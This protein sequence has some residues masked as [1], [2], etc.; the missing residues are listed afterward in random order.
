MILKRIKERSARKVLNKLLK[1]H[2]P[3]VKKADSKESLTIGC[4]VDVEVMPDVT[5]MY[6]LAKAFNL[7]DNQ[8]KII[9]YQDKLDSVSPFAVP[10]FSEAD[11]GWNG[12]IKSGYV[13]EF[14]NQEFDVLINYYT[15][16]KLPLL[17]L[18]AKTKAQ[19]KVGFPVIN[20]ELNNLIINVAP[21][22]FEAF[23]TELKKYTT[24]LKA[25]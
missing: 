8:I 5:N 23:V 13:T 14:L 20:Q 1:Q 22:N 11:L 4:I 19:L 24:I 15:V 6:Q 17:L 3:E 7:R 9:G 18:T 12:T 25:L 21:T 16:Q 2:T 10:M